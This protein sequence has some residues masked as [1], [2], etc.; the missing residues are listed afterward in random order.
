LEE[1][2]RR[3]RDVAM[4]EEQAQA[5]DDIQ[6]VSLAVEAMKRRVRR[7]REASTRR[8]ERT[9]ALIRESEARILRGPPKR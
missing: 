7:A 4:T 9:A 6:A 1:S 2:S 3:I 8:C 5:L